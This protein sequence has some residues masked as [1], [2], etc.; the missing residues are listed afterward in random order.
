M[1][2]HRKLLAV[3]FVVI[4]SASGCTAVDYSYGHGDGLINWREYNDC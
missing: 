3:L 1:K 2:T 4:L